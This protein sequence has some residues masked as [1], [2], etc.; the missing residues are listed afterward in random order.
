MDELL[1]SHAL[2]PDLLRRDAFDDFME[3]RRRRLS[4]L[5]ETAIGKAVVQVAEGG[6]Y[7]DRDE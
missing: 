4:R 3:D 5:V 1:A 2:A 7:E 6:D